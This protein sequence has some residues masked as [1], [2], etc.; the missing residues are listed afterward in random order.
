M[1]IP[2]WEVESTLLSLSLFPYPTA[3]FYTKLSDTLTHSPIGMLL[4]GTVISPS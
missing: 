4:T 2:I 3:A 1:I